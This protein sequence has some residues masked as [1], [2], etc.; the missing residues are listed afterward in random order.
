MANLISLCNVKEKFKVTYDSDVEDCFMVHKPDGVRKFRATT[1][2]LY[3]LK[4][5]EMMKEKGKDGFQFLQTVEDNKSM[6]SQ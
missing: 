4:V 1:N 3:T 6:F 5:G 2:G